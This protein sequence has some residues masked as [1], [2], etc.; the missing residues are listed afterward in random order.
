MTFR[1]SINVTKFKFFLQELRQKFIYDD[2]ILVLDNLAVH[3]NKGSKERMEELG[4]RYTWVPPYSPE[5]N[6]GIEETWSQGKMK[7]KGERMKR[8]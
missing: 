8:Y 6:G 3:K 1:K 5:L 7:I 2:I 4:F